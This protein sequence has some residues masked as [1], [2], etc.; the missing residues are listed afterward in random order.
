MKI[1]VGLY[2]EN[3]NIDDVDLTEPEKGN[4]GVG[5][6]QFNFVTLP[7]Y[8]KKNFPERVSFI[9]YANSTKN[10]PENISAS[11]VKSPTEGAEKAD[12][13]GCDIYVWRP[14]TDEEGQE[15]IENI[16]SF[17][18]KTVAWVHNT[19]NNEALNKL[20]RSEQLKRFVTVSQEQMDRLRDH[21]IINKTTCIFNGFDP[22]PYIPDH[23]LGGTRKTV[24][25]IGSLVPA[26]GFHKLARVWPQVRENVPEANMIVIGSG[27]LYDRS[28]SL[29][30][31]G[32][33]E[34]HYE[35]E[36]I[37]PYLSDS[38]G[39]IDESVDFKGVLGNEKIPIIQRAS[40]GA[41]NPSG[42][43]ENCPGS[44]IELQAAKTPV[45]S[46]AYRGLLDTVKHKETG[47][48]GRGDQDLI[49]NI[50]Y[51]L[52]NEDV[53]QKYGENGLEFVKQKF[54]YKKISK[55]WLSL[56]E[57]VVEGRPN[58]VELIKQYPLN[59]LKI[60]REGV[61]LTRK[62]IPGLQYL[63]NP[64]IPTRLQVENKVRSFW[65]KLSEVINDASFH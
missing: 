5:G 20:S 31:W 64:N 62:H 56:F 4:P 29:G 22:S 53:A 23:Y 49:N 55:Q 40:V 10:L 26:K 19:P 24:V 59:D 3:R 63:P 32:V 12:K 8:F 34:E 1:K 37:R 15:F 65:R 61:R 41:V 44:A 42:A 46:G 57:D 13:D 11:E 36:H 9:W 14:T 47:L 2:L 18:V 28:Q 35:S 50:V 30:K 43:T 58:E 7:Y 51:L 17:D 6:T 39:E 33:A 60:F 48:L 38:G 52:E 27:K 25:Y 54:S 21:R 16:D 45:V